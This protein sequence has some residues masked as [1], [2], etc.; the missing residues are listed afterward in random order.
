MVRMT[1]GAYSGI[2]PGRDF[3]DPGGGELS[4][5]A[6]PSPSEYEFEKLF[7][8]SNSDIFKNSMS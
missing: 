8:F 7:K 1:S 3:N 4:H 5:S 2:C 6:K